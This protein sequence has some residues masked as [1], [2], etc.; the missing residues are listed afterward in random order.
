MVG[1]QRDSRIT[2]VTFDAP[3]GLRSKRIAPGQLGRA[4][5]GRPRGELRHGEWQCR[6]ERAPKVE[7]GVVLQ[8]MTLGMKTSRFTIAI[9]GLER[10]Q[11]RI[12]KT[13]LTPQ[14]QLVPT[15]L[16]EDG[17]S[18]SAPSGLREE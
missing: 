3:P 2:D 13:H 6:G 11:I 4:R 17:W 5:S 1:D 8:R 12:G 9:I 15:L 18:L 16:E 14:T 7:C 10:V